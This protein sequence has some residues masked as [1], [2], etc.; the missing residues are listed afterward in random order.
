MLAYAGKGSFLIEPV[1]VSELVREISALLSSSISR[2]V[3]IELDLSDGLPPVEADPAQIQQ[4]VMNL[5]INGAEAIGDQPG[6]VHVS[7]SVK[8]MDGPSTGQMRGADELLPGLYVAI[9]V[10]DNGSGMDQSTM[11]QI[12]DPFFTTKFTGRGLGLAA[13]LGIVRSHRGGIAVYS[14]PGRGSRFCVFLPATGTRAQARETAKTAS[15][16]NGTGTILVIDDEV[17][18]RRAAQAALERYGYRVLTAENGQVGVDLFR[19]LS[20]QIHL[21]LLD[22]TMPVMSGEATLEQIRRIRRNVPVLLSSGFDDSE[23][24]R[25]FS[26]GGPAEFV[27]K[28]YTSTALAEKVKRA[29]N[30]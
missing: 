3:K 21:V 24:V 26:H 6:T 14:E 23:A 18:V 8:D 20:G 17:F 7:T 15:E 28:P 29:L 13:A 12:F 1:N 30:P 4:I 25:K 9:E 27:Q 10:E 22:L 11:E 5:V 19:R 2:Q 16:L